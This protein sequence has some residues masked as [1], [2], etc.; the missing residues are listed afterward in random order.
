[1]PQWFKD[2]AA[3]L[4]KSQTMRDASFELIRLGRM[5]WDLPGSSGHKSY[6]M[7]YKHFAELMQT[8]KAYKGGFITLAKA[9]LDSPREAQ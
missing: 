5:G 2:Y 3:E 4:G 1:M 6:C 9:I 8:E 7:A